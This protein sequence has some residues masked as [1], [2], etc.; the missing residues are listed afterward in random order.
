[1]KH[2]NEPV[3]KD[4][5]R[6]SEYRVSCRLC[7][8]KNSKYPKDQI[9]RHIDRVHNIKKQNAKATLKGWL[10]GN[11]NVWKPVFLASFEKDPPATSEVEGY[12]DMDLTFFGHVF[13][14]DEY[15]CHTTGP[16]PGDNGETGFIESGDRNKTPKP[17]TSRM[18]SKNR[19]SCN[20]SYEYDLAQ[21]DTKTKEIDPEENGGG[22]KKV[23]GS[24]NTCPMEEEVV[25]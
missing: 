19:Y 11:G 23:V 17:G 20:K 4:I 3:D 9:A 13:K 6:D 12:D 7:S 18:S 15:T 1:M 25:E 22:V 14:P 16:F 21:V 8:G 5:E 10:T 2:P 24:D